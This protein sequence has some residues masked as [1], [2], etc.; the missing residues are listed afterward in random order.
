MTVRSQPDLGGKVTY[1]AAGCK[2]WRCKVC[3]PKKA[4]KLRKGIAKAAEE[5]KLTRMLTLT[6]DTKF[7]TE[8]ELKDSGIGYIRQSW[9]KLRV[10]LQREYGTAIQFIAIVELQSAMSLIFTFWWTGIYLNNG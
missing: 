8:A 3:G 9:R 7:L 2:A 5:K 6:L 10:Y 1:L 4:D